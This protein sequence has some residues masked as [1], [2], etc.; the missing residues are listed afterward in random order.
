MSFVGQ[1]RTAL[2]STAT[3]YFATQHCTVSQY[4]SQLACLLANP[5]LITP[6]PDGGTYVQVKNVPFPPQ[7]GGYAMCC[8]FSEM[9]S[10]NAPLCRGLELVNEG[11]IGIIDFLVDNFYDGV[12]PLTVEAATTVMD[13]ACYDW[14]AKQQDAL[15]AAT[16]LVCPRVSQSFP[17]SSP[18]S[19]FDQ[20]LYR[21][22]MSLDCCTGSS[23]INCPA[24][25]CYESPA[26]SELL[27]DLCVL[28]NTQNNVY[29]RAWRSFSTTVSSAY[30]QGDYPTTVDYQAQSVVDYCRSQNYGDRRTCGAIQ[31]IQGLVFDRIIPQV[32]TAHVQTISTTQVAVT[33]RNVSGR[34]VT[35]VIIH[36]TNSLFQA[37]PDTVSFDPFGS[38][39]V[40][41][42]L[43]NTPDT[44]NA[45]TQTSYT[46][47]T[48]S[49][50][51]LDRMN[52]CLNVSDQNNPPPLTT[53]R[54]AVPHECADGDL[55]LGLTYNFTG[56]TAQVTNA[57]ALQSAL[58]TTSYG[59]FAGIT[60]CAGC[61]RGFVYDVDSCNGRFG[62]S[63]DACNNHGP[64]YMCPFC[65]G[66]GDLKGLPDTIVDGTHT[67]VLYR[68][69]A[70][71][72]WSG[73]INRSNP[74]PNLGGCHCKIN[75]DIIKCRGDTRGTCSPTTIT[76]FNL[77]TTRNCE[78]SN[79]IT[80][81]RFSNR[82]D[83][84]SNDFP[85]FGG[86]VVAYAPIGMAMATNALQ[87][88]PIQQNSS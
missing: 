50:V 6:L 15:H 28:T 47:W 85:V 51:N 61:E 52:R 88:F 66:P 70:Q 60:G 75:N 37:S 41:F 40:T 33:L 32:T 17:Y 35:N 7:G 13:D 34:S 49:G 56:G 4:T 25:A 57:D 83:L 27:H 87:V 53:D 38:T 5:H 65:F 81:F 77:T 68:E 44:S 14:T 74:D 48:Q 12:Q 64:D 21:Q 63:G 39:V 42:S 29:C 86:I 16:L 11:P 22:P 43:L 84:T 9:Y 67:T 8:G 20:T 19:R 82:S 58:C 24:S 23:A 45:Y 46:V 79:A 26:C 62:V 30:S 10:S 59:D 55:D 2:K 1:D 78:G 72:N 73:D 76:A 3:S 54:Y 18:V 71:Q 31:S 36:G 80:T 69:I